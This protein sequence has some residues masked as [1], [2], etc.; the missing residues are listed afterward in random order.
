MENLLAVLSIL[1]IHLR[2][3]NLLQGIR[4][5]QHLQTGSCCPEDCTAID[6]ALPSIILAHV[7]CLIL[8]HLIIFVHLVCY[9]H[10][11]CTSK[12]HILSI[13]KFAL[14]NR[15]KMEQAFSKWTE[16]SYFIWNMILYLH[17][18]E[19]LLADFFKLRS[20]FFLLT[21]IFVLHLLERSGHTMNMPHS[22]P[23]L[24]GV[25]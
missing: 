2:E 19:L 5:W 18:L 21:C 8:C 15:W 7:F 11:V 17:S 4:I 14:G 20:G 3:I 12:T 1:V 23:S 25:F 22:L 24:S 6:S 16:K 10:P 13:E 9:I